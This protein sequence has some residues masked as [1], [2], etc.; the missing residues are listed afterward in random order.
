MYPVVCRTQKRFEEQA[1]EAE[2]GNMALKTLPKGGVYLV[3]EEAKALEE[4]LLTD[5][6]QELFKEAFCDSERLDD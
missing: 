1:R 3:G 5:N 4:Y 6:G 2:A